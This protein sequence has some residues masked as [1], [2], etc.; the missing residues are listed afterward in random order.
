MKG[1]GGRGMLVLSRGVGESLIIGNNVVVTV[2][3]IDRGIVRL[4]VRAPRTV[5]VDRTEI[6]ARK[7][8]NG[9]LPRGPVVSR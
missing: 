4:Q 9:E 1:K 8:A 6:R 3:G 2:Q 5:S 7:E